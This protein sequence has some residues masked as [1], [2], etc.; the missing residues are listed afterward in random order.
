MTERHSNLERADPVHNPRPA[1]LVLGQVRRGSPALPDLA[2]QRQAS[3]P[4]PH[5]GGNPNPNLIPNPNL[6]SN[7]ILT[8]TMAGGLGQFTNQALGNTVW[9][10]AKL[11][12]AIRVRP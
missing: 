6:S 5:S 1:A 11:A 7:L 12:D 3:R 4:A 2:P 10:Y 9:A 8:L